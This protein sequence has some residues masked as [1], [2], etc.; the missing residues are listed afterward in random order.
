MA[1][2]PPCAANFMAPDVVSAA[3]PAFFVF[4]TSSAAFNPALAFAALFTS[5]LPADFVAFKA[6]FE[7]VP[8]A[9]NNC[10]NN[11]SKLGVIYAIAS[12]VF[13]GREAKIFFALARFVK[14]LIFDY[15]QIYVKS[16]IFLRTSQAL[17]VSSNSNVY[18]GA[19]LRKI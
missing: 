6:G 19:I 13:L 4:I 15:I 10:L 5:F 7:I 9:P 14:L 18:I 1:A 8:A 17:S 11:L 2:L 3:C 12:A 16:Q